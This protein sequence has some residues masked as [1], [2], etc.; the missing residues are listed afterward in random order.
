MFS[1]WLILRFSATEVTRACSPI[2]QGVTLPLL[3]GGLR[4]YAGASLL[5]F[6]TFFLH[7][8]SLYIAWICLSKLSAAKSRS[9]RGHRLSAES[10][11]V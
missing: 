8:P 9:Y 1:L 2:Y 4:G 6:C 10:E 7:E 11:R 3:A 5:A